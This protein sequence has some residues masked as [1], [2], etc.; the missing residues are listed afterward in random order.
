MNFS[1]SIIDIIKERVSCRTYS[2]QPLEK[3]IRENVIK[4][5]ENHDL[6]SPFSEFAGRVRF[7][8]VSVPD[9]DPNESKKLGTY[10]LIKGVQD[11]VVGAVEKSQFDREHYGY[12]METIILTLTDIGLGTCWLGGFFNRSLFASKIET[13]SDEIVPAIT[14]IGYPAQRSTTEKIIR[15][16]AKA[17]K[18]LSWEQLFF[19]GDLSASLTTIKAGKYSKLLEM[20]QLGPS[21][22]NKQPWRIIKTIGK[23]KFHF[24]SINPKDGRF[25]KY[26]KFR[27][28]DIGIAVC[29]FDL[30]AKELGIK[31][32]WLFESPNITGTEDLLYKITWNENE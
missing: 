32:N 8:L 16:F 29:H 4:L 19:E 30:A 23:K 10:G 27:P 11:F 25:L 1:K 5:L 15:A 24:Y 7:K 18:R 13:S 31:G 3:D 2:G 12:L 22:G 28:L 6:K 17:N 9:F 26:S 21:A 20:V 14:P